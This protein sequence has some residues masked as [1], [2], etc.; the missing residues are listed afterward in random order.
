MVEQQNRPIKLNVL[1]E[2]TGKLSC[3]AVRFL[4]VYEFINTGLFFTLFV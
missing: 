1:L 2:Q 4:K 3:N